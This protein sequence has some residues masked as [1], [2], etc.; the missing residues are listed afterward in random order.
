M[1]NLW[2]FEYAGMVKLTDTDGYI[3]IGDA[4]EVTDIGERSDLER[5]EDGITLFIEGKY[6]EFLQVRL[7][8]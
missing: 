8:A 1:I 6:V 4:Q 7:P 5:M 3:Y 2:K